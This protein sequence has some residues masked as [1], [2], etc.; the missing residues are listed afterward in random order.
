[1]RKQLSALEGLA[2]LLV[3]LPLALW[4]SGFWLLIP[5]AIVLFTGRSFDDYG[6]LWKTGSARLHL[7][8]MPL[9]LGGYALGH[10]LFAHFFQGAVFRPQLPPQ[11]H[12]LVIQQLVDVALPEEF[13]FRGYLQTNLNQAWGRPMNTLGATWGWGL[14][15]AAVLFALCHLFYGDLTQL[16][17]VFFGLFAGWLRERTGSIVAPIFYHAAG[18]IL[19]QIMVLSFRG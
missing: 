1:M 12:L 11:L 7:I 2:L 9:V 17:V 6:L 4:Q 18:N 8:T 14:P 19:L 5:F 10:F 16:R 15:V 13:F 3:T